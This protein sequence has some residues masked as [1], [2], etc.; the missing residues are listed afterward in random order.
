M[1]NAIVKMATGS[2]VIHKSAEIL[3]QFANPSKTKSMPVEVGMTKS[4]HFDS[5]TV[6]E[7]YR[8]SIE[9]TSVDSNISL[10]SKLSFVD[11]SGGIATSYANEVEQHYSF[12]GAIEV[13]ADSSETTKVTF[14][15]PPGE[16]ITFYEVTVSA[17]GWSHSYLT[18]VN[19]G[20]PESAEAN[21]TI[22]L[23]LSPIFDDFLNCVIANSCYETTDSDEWRQLYNNAIGAKSKE[24]PVDRMQSFIDSCASSLWKT[25]LDQDSW[26]A[27]IDG[28]KLAQ[29]DTGSNYS[30]FLAMLKSFVNNNNPSR[31]ADA[32]GAI[33]GKAQ[34]YILY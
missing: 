30:K 12:S 2:V 16:T 21:F 32:W 15:V 24:T 1:E 4:S 17:E 5:K 27:V 3:K 26:A 19:P 11:V 18:N 6:I 10:E 22:S 31:N 23:D 14:E 28:M 13:V 29:A 25:G 9:K 7:S 33:R 20:G 34:A 8:T